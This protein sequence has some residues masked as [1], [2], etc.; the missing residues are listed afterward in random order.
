M[1][2]KDLIDNIKDHSISTANSI[3]KK[4]WDAEFNKIVYESLDI[5]VQWLINNPKPV[6]IHEN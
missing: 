2:F 4:K 5:I 3:N 1:D 6:L